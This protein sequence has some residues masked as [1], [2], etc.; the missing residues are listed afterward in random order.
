MKAIS[1]SPF[2]VQKPASK[3][4]DE[5]TDTN[6]T[7]ISEKYKRK[8]DKIKA[9]LD[10]EINLRK[11]IEAKLIESKNLSSLAETK[12]N[13]DIK[14]HL[15][16]IFELKEKLRISEIE[17]A[18]MSVKLAELNLEIE[19]IHKENKS[20]NEGFILLKNEL[21]VSERNLKIWKQKFE[22]IENH[23]KQQIIELNRLKC[24]VE[25][26]DKNISA[27]QSDYKNKLLTE[28]SKTH[29][30]VKDYLS[31]KSEMF[32]KSI[33]NYK[34]AA[35]IMMANL[36]KRNL[37]HSKM[38]ALLKTKQ[39]AVLKKLNEKACE[40]YRK[41]KEKAHLAFYLN[42]WKFFCKSQISC[43][44][45]LSSSLKILKSI[46]RTKI[47]NNFIEKFTLWKIKTNKRKKYLLKREKHENEMVSKI[48]KIKTLKFMKQSFDIW[49]KETLN[50]KSAN[51]INFMYKIH[52]KEKL[53]LCLSI[54]I[55]KWKN[56]A[57][58]TNLES[59]AK[60]YSQ[61][62]SKLEFSEQQNK[63]LTKLI[64]NWNLKNLF[65]IL[66]KKLMNRYHI[67]NEIKSYSEDRL[68]LYQGFKIFARLEKG[69]T[70]RKFNQWR[71]N[72][73]N[74][75]IDYLCE[76]HES[77][78]LDKEDLIANTN[79]LEKVVVDLKD[80]LRSQFIKKADKIDK[81]LRKN[82]MRVNFDTI[83]EIYIK[84]KRIN[85]AFQAL[86]SIY[87]AHNRSLG[88]KFIIDKYQQAI[89]KIK[90]RRKVTEY[91]RKKNFLR[92]R[93]VFLILKK[94]AVVSKFSKKALYRIMKRNKQ[95]EI[96]NNFK[97][98]KSLTASMDMDD[99]K[100]NLNK[101]KEDQKSTNSKL[102]QA[103][104]IIEES[105]KIAQMFELNIK[106]KILRSLYI[107]FEKKYTEIIYRS[108]EKWNKTAKEIKNKIKCEKDNAKVLKKALMI[109]QRKE[110]IEIKMRVQN[111]FHNWLL[112][113]RN[114]FLKTKNIANK[115]SKLQLWKKSIIMKA[116]KKYSVET[117]ISK[118]KL[119]KELK[120]Q[121]KLKISSAI[122]KW[123]SAI[124]KEKFEETNQKV[125]SL[126]QEKEKDFSN[127]AQMTQY[128]KLSEINREN[129]EK[130]LRRLV[131][132][133]MIKIIES[134]NSYFKKDAIYILKQN[135]LMH[136]SSE[137]SLMK[138][139]KIKSK[140]L[141][142]QVFN[143]WNYCLKVQLKIE[144][145][146]LTMS[147]KKKMKRYK[148]K[149]QNT[150]EKHEELSSL[151]ESQRNFMKSKLNRVLENKQQILSI[152][153]LKKTLNA[154]CSLHNQ[155]KCYLKSALK[156]KEMMAIR[157]AFGILKKMSISQ[158]KSQFKQIEQAFSI[159]L[160]K[161][162]ERASILLKLLKKEGIPDNFIYE[163]ISINES[164]SLMR[165]QLVSP[166]RKFKKSP[167]N[168]IVRKKVENS[169][170]KVVSV[171]QNPYLLYSFKKWKKT[172]NQ[173][174]EK[175]Q[176]LNR[177]QLFN[178]IKIL[179]KQI[180]GLVS[181]Q[182]K[183]LAKITKF[184]AVL[185]SHTKNCI[186]SKNVAV[187]VIV[188]TIKNSIFSAFNIWNIARLNTRAQE[189]IGFLNEKE[190]EL[191]SYKRKILM[192]EEEKI[193]GEMKLKK[194]NEDAD[195]LVF[196]I[197]ELT[198]ERDDLLK[199]LSDREVSIRKLLKENS[200]LA[201]KLS[202]AQVEAEHLIQ[203]AE[204]SFMNTE[205]DLFK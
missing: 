46:F 103:L 162:K 56:N 79:E 125:L 185:N 21:N 182:E 101:F 7:T 110:K 65:N 188:K 95:K 29:G 68:N 170:R 98:W 109:F 84:G 176:H 19:K 22:E 203:L 179:E 12:F 32:R 34:K 8:Y 138:L 48:F 80:E 147:N 124:E 201:I 187:A 97:K 13:Q 17:K 67:F 1:K 177:H 164:S 172:V 81:M 204:D 90:R 180:S 196:A 194:Q 36:L 163:F 120:T 41:N 199:Q 74:I 89:Y 145:A 150:V 6:F 92:K 27:L 20:L 142:K 30:L 134:S 31:M 129:T 143:L 197:S 205:K 157:L 114:K 113:I 198:E 104:A 140:F 181:Q 28:K 10:I 61:E 70:K 25:E 173:Y 9:D 158:F 86:L 91:L 193:K 47:H 82:L 51:S 15:E 100:Q 108:L 153:L 42:S 156:I 2:R 155:K 35:T 38:E 183:N 190:R 43:K 133:K 96:F 18:E 87:S 195:K 83:K 75:N 130:A 186:K 16:S 33:K 57:I 63:C 119:L 175:Y 71:V 174:I 76:Q 154:W 131:I 178:S 161:Y 139:G 5:D 88:F 141:M 105:D 169:V 14:K 49:R 202:K 78:R 160:K 107:R 66:E 166:S 26:K 77:H 24:E 127:M 64:K 85:S 152:K 171:L 189:I 4:W 144:N 167:T 40:A 132:G 102:V 128:Y 55:Q 115:C 137:E 60:C 99:M 121:I 106:Q 93:V 117:L 73:Y 116:W 94:L 37:N 45:K 69:Q 11:S 44:A 58:K 111:K 54:C 23:E 146:E 118:K 151:Y 148:E 159:E 72:V 126:L 50:L 62:M 52:E 136:K 149:M 53:S 191:F 135:S 200:T 3:F 59:N 184:Q 39:F 122:L 123:K 168:N 192:I 165:S 112:Y